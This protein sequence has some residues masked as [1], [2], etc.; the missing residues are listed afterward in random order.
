MKRMRLRIAGTWMLAA[1]L[2]ACCGCASSSSGPRET[3]AASAAGAGAGAAQAPTG[4]VWG[5]TSAMD[6]LRAGG[7]AVLGAVL[8]NEVV[9]ARVPLIAA[10]D[11]VLA[12]RWADVPI[13]RYA[14]VRAALDDS[15]ARLL[16][17]GYQLHGRAEPLWLGRAAD[18]LK[19]LARYG[20]LARVRRHR[21]IEEER[22]SDR[23]RTPESPGPYKIRA[24]I[25]E[26]DVSVHL[27]DLATRGLLFAGEFQGYAEQEAPS[28]SLPRPE[29]P[30]ITTW[31]T[32][33]D[34]AMEPLTRPIGGFPEPPPLA[35]SAADA[36]AAF[37]DS[38]VG[39]GR[40]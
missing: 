34:R 16:L 20:V 7:V 18:S 3:A 22:E 15:T 17:L 33:E 6:S 31:S 2:L 40:R 19:G 28:D 21:L 23:V 10:L 39:S 38:I 12:S 13:R 32:P 27:Y 35:R 26:S 1:A 8:V 29:R 11:S 5:T 36:Y 24:A 37:A 25:L 30:P 9:Q 14:S 4:A